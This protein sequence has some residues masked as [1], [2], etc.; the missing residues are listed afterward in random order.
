MGVLAAILAH[1]RYVTAD[2]T[3]VL[4]GLVEGRIKQ[5]DQ[6]GVLSH[7]MRVQRI[8]CLLG[9]LGRGNA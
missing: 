6:L 9:T 8:Q 1:A 4:R 7:Q 2:V 5:L 3:W